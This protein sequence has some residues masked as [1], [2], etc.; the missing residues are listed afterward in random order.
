MAGGSGRGSPS[1]SIVIP[2]MLTPWLTHGL[3][4]T[5]CK[6]T[7]KALDDAQTALSILQQ[8][9]AACPTNAVYSRNIGLC[10]EKLAAALERLGADE[11]RSNA[12]RLTSWSQA[13]G[14]FEKASQLFSNLRDRGTP[15]P[16]D[17]EQTTKFERQIRDC[18]AAISRLKGNTRSVDP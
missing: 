4:P 16:A 2:G 10:Y 7:T 11:N 8:L 15:M 12:Q 17:S 14:W 6:S 9:S 3:V 13:R 1:K 18:D 5:M